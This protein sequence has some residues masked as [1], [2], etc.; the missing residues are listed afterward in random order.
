MRQAQCWIPG[1]GNCLS[2]CHPVQVFIDIS[3][4]AGGGK[5]LGRSEPF[6][7]A[8]VGQILWVLLSVIANVFAGL[9][10]AKM[11]VFAQ[12]TGGDLPFPI[13]NQFYDPEALVDFHADMLSLCRKCGCWCA[14]GIYRWSWEYREPAPLLTNIWNR[15]SGY[16]I[17]ETIAN[18]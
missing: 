6:A 1:L 10:A 2:A 18:G 14:P 8:A 11:K 17:V 16:C 12:V 9:L 4:D 3:C 15:S 5:V 7:A 13:G